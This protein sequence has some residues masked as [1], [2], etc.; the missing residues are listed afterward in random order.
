MV[1]QTSPVAQPPRIPTTT[2]KSASTISRPATTAE[3]AATLP[4]ERSMPA[5][6][7]TRI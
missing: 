5:V 2:G 6:K 3:K 1:P 7:M 4:T